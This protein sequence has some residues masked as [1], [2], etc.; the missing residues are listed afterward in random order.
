MNT[1][2]TV[3]SSLPLRVLLAALLALVAVLALLY[4][5]LFV[6][7]RSELRSGAAAAPS[8][9]G[10][11][12]LLKSLKGGASVSDDNKKE[13][14][15]SMGADSVSVSEEEKLDVLQGLGNR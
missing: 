7:S 2:Q 8:E 5:S 10:R 11:F 13:I 1:R 6:V 15:S 12:L 14:L 4:S 9:E 3:L